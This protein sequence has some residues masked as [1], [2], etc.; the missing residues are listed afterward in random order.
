MNTRYRL[1]PW[2][3]HNMTGKINYWTRSQ[4]KALHMLHL[5]KYRVLR[6]CIMRTYGRHQ[7]SHLTQCLLY[8]E[9]PEECMD[10]CSLPFPCLELSLLSQFLKQN[11]VREQQDVF[12]FVPVGFSR[13]FKVLMAT[14]TLWAGTHVHLFPK[15]TWQWNHFLLGACHK[16]GIV[17]KS[18][19]EMLF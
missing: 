13:A 19:G 2:A 14:M 9:G 1:Y 4:R 7:E 17:Q 15:C 12:P 6:E 18:S 3:V 11:R 5:G 10:A 16:P 8:V